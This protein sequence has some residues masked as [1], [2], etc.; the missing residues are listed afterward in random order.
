MKYSSVMYLH[1]GCEA[2]YKKRHDEL[3]PELAKLLKSY[4]ITNYYIY[5]DETESRLYA[6]FDADNLESERLAS[7]P[8]M[9]RWWAYMADI[10]ETKAGSFEPAATPLQEVFRFNIQDVHLTHVVAVLDI[11]KTN[12]KICLMDAQTGVLKEVIKRPNG[13]VHEGPYPHIDVEAIWQWVKDSFIELTPSYRINSIAITTHGATAACMKGDELALPVL[14]YEYDAID[15]CRLEYA[16]WRAPFSETF[17]PLLPQGLNL[18]KQIFWQQ[19][20]YPEAFSEVTDILLYPQYWGFRLSGQK[21][22]EVTS[23]GCHTD[24][25][26]SSNCQFSQLSVRK[27]WDKLFPP[28]LESGAKLGNILPELAEET[29]LPKNCV[30]FNGIHDSNASL[31]PYISKPLDSLTVISSGTWTVI[32]TINGELGTLDEHKDMLANV[33]AYGRATPTIRFMGGREWETLRSEV[34][35]TLEDISFILENGVFALPSFASSG[36]PFAGYQGYIETRG[37]MLT[38]AQQSALADVYVAL[39]TDYCIDLLGESDT[40]VVEGAFSNNVNFLTLLSSLKSNSEI[41]ASRDVTGTAG[42]AALLS[43]KSLKHKGRLSLAQCESTL[44]PLLNLYRRQ[45]REQVAMME[46][47]VSVHMS[48]MTN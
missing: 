45:W 18:G 35:A 17:S 38:P 3:W 14:D 42:G 20:L 29:G 36:G 23:L 5:L 37:I 25:W 34:N 15:Q 47:K 48:T 27:G 22:S 11:G 40:T 1:K 28:L 4:G 30:I 32:A 2:E 43:N 12:I 7:E 6:S 31:V 21:V 26:N 44:K 13:V 46:K 39:M 19:S 10:M 9:Q 16:A 8:I 24:L 33:D 41:Y